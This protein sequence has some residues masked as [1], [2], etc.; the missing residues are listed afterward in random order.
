MGSVA[1]DAG[2]AEPETESWVQEVYLWTGSEEGQGSETEKEG[3]PTQGWI[4]DLKSTRGLV[5]DP[6]GNFRGAFWNVS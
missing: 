3:K 4:I 2:K 6:T 1:W 5:L